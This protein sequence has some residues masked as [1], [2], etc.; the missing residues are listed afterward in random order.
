MDTDT[1][2]RWF[3][4]R[5]DLFGCLSYRWWVTVNG[6]EADSSRD[7]SRAHCEGFAAQRADQIR[8]LPAEEVQAMVRLVRERRISIYGR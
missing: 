4:E 3:V 7:S 1:D 2:V 8:A 5:S 6:D